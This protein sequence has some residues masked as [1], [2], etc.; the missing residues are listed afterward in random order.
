MSVAFDS[1]KAQL[2]IFFLVFLTS[3][4]KRILRCF[5]RRYCTMRYSLCFLTDL[6]FCPS[7]F[8]VDFKISINKFGSIEEA[9]LVRRE[10]KSC[11]P[12]DN[13]RSRLIVSDSGRT[14]GSCSATFSKSSIAMYSFSVSRSLS[15]DSSYESSSSSPVIVGCLSNLKRVDVE[16]CKLLESLLDAFL[17][18]APGIRLMPC[19]SLFFSSISSSASLVFRDRNGE[20]EEAS[21]RVS[22]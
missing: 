22:S 5:S 12:F 6:I 3:C 16:R 4:S 20:Q 7:R 9:S 18:N 21:L 13:S 1:P 19:S 8:S 15:S 11:F 2:S 10:C 14:S 17:V